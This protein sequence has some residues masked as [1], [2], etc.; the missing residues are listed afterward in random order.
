MRV[1]IKNKAK[2]SGIC[3]DLYLL[4]M[5]KFHQSM[6]GGP[7]IIHRIINNLDEDHWM[8]SYKTFDFIEKYMVKNDRRT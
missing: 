8:L 5:S 4:D 7:N 1:N 3:R 6:Y 2:M